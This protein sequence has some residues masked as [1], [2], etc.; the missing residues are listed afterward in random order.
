MRKKSTF[1]G[2]TGL[3]ERKH[4]RNFIGLELNPQYVEMAKKRLS[5]WKPFFLWP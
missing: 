3:V 4:N 1:T 5:N 2:T